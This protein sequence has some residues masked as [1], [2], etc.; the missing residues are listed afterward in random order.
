MLVVYVAPFGSV[1]L[2]HAFRLGVPRYRD[3]SEVTRDRATGQILRSPDFDTQSS[4]DEAP[5]P[6]REMR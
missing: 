2:P 6:H 3:I 4:H 1:P 5:T